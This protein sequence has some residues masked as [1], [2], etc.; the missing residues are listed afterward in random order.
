VANS[1]RLS[2]VFLNVSAVVTVAD[3]DFENSFMVT[4]E[5]DM[6]CI[7][8]GMESIVLLGGIETVELARTKEFIEGSS[9]L[10]LLRLRL[11]AGAVPLVASLSIAPLDEKLA[12]DIIS[13][14]LSS[15]AQTHL[16]DEVV[17]W[18]REL[19]VMK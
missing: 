12:I 4:D 9:I 16:G 10:E 6:E 17:S 13:R 18:N 7:K 15:V 1:S 11:R 14:V 5:V 19:V 3:P 2:A 8:V